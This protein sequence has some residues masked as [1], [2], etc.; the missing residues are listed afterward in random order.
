MYKNRKAYLDKKKD[1]KRIIYNTINTLE[2]IFFNINNN[3]HDYHQ[4]KQHVHIINV[5]LVAAIIT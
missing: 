5:F 3:G 4:Q 1:N 2:H